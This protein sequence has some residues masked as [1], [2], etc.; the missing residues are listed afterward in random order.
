VARLHIKYRE[1]AFD[2]R[3]L[4]LT[5]RFIEVRPWRGSYSERIRKFDI[6]LHGANLVYG[7]PQVA[8]HVSPKM[9]PHGVGRYVAATDEAPAMICLAKFSV[10]SLFHQFRHHMQANAQA[11]AYDTDEEGAQDAQAWACSLYYVTDT[12]R[13]RKAVRKGR[14][15]GVKPND[16]LKTRRTA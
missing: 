16:L 10:I 9:A 14:V 13:Y 11:G 2:E 3:L 4:E 7:M 5:R 12:K 1:G 15:A 6:W 8:L